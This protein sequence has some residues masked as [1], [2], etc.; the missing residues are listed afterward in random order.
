[1][2]YRGRY[3]D[4]G[5]G[6]MQGVEAPQERHHVLAAMHYITQQI[7]QQK[8]RHPVYPLIGYCPRGPIGERDAECRLKL[9]SKAADDRLCPPQPPLP[10]VRQPEG[11]PSARADGQ[12]GRIPER[13]L[14]RRALV[15][16]L[17]L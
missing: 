14:W 3:I 6:V 5:I 9:W 8:R 12:P 13:R 7:E 16:L 11:A 2:T 10:A 15:A 4:I 17:L 1:M